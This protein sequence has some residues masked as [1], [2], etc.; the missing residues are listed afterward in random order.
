MARRKKLCGAYIEFVGDGKCTRIECKRGPTHNKSEH[1]SGVDVEGEGDHWISWGYDGGYYKQQA[2]LPSSKA[3]FKEPWYFSSASE[4]RYVSRDGNTQCFERTPRAN[5]DLEGAIVEQ[6]MDC[7]YKENGISISGDSSI[8][9]N[10]KSTKA[11]SR[12]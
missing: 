2:R 11:R 1:E 9:S 3:V 6:D 7:F 10:P 4:V 12:S 8:D 5:A